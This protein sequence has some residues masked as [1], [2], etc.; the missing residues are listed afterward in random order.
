MVDIL[1]HS[2]GTSQSHVGEIPA[3]SEKGILDRL[4]VV[5]QEEAAKYQEAMKDGKAFVAKETNTQR[6]LRE[7]YGLYCSLQVRDGTKTP[8]S[9][10]R[11]VCITVDP[12]NSLT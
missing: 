9:S 2:V 7:V 10:D 3:C 12:T 1:R 11:L 6:K 8:S 5:A 4:S